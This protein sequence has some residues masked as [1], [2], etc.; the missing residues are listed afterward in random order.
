[1]RALAAPVARLL[2]QALAAA[3]AGCL[4]VQ[5]GGRYIEHLMHMIA[6]AAHRLIRLSMRVCNPTAKK[7]ANELASCMRGLVNIAVPVFCWLSGS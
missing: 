7:G 2:T 3:A 5:A 4:D 1:M 6:G